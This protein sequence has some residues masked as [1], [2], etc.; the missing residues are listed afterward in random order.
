VPTRESPF[1]GEGAMERSRTPT[2]SRL[3]T[4]GSDGRR[5]SLQLGLVVQI[6]GFSVWVCAFVD[7]LCL[8]T[9]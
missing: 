7:F 8:T 2:W 9:S 5:P 6:L 1:P 3:P 4:E